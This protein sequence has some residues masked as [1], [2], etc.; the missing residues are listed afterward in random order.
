MIFNN[1]EKSHLLV[2]MIFDNISSSKYLEQEKEVISVSIS[3]LASEP[4]FLQP[5]QSCQQQLAISTRNY[6]II[7]IDLTSSD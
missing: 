1:D 2:E 4:L 7:T 6:N 3:E 5:E